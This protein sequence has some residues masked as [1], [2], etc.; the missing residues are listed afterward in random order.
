MNQASGLFL[1]G[2]NHL[3][4]AMP[5]R[6]HGDPGCEIEKAVPIGVLDDG[7]LASFCDQGI[8]AGVGRRDNLLIPLNN[9]LCLGA[10][11]RSEDVRELAFYI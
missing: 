10:G 5:R 9:C 11:E 7:A 4:V 3:G 6:D 8:V 2:F 1:N